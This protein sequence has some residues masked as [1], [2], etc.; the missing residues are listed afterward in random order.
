MSDVHKNKKIAVLTIALVS[1]TVAGIRIALKNNSIQKKLNETKTSAIKDIENTISELKNNLEVKTTAQLQKT[2][3]N[4][5]ELAKQ[6][7]DKISNQI[8]SDLQHFQT[9]INHAS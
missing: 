9:R 4:S 3:D 8:K 6:N 1:L 5:I 2:I 7:L